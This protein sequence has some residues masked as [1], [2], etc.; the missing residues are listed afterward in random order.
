MSSCQSLPPSRSTRQSF[1][2]TKAVTAAARQNS[3]SHA[4]TGLANL[5]ANETTIEEKTKKHYGLEKPSLVAWLST[6]KDHN[7]IR[8]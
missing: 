8:M 7:Y 6:W 5:I 3:Y 2:S 1:D 4:H